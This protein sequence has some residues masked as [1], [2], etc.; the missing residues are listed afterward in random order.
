MSGDLP[1]EGVVPEE[2]SSWTALIHPY[3]QSSSQKFDKMFW[4]AFSISPF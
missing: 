3:N 4:I 2:G 1:D